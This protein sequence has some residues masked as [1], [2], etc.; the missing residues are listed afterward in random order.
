[1]QTR[2]SNVTVDK[3]VEVQMCWGELNIDRL[4]LNIGND[5]KKYIR[6]CKFAV[7]FLCTPASSVHYEKVFLK[8]GK[9][10]SKETNCL[11]PSTVERL[12]FFN[13]S[14]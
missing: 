12:V 5:R 7:V 6:T 1:M 14:E 4:P 13:K 2:T 9:I 10:L 8:A 11:R 3:T